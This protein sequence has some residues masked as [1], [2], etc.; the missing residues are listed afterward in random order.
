M[1]VSP[2]GNRPGSYEVHSRSGKTYVV[3]YC[4]SGDTDRE[5]PS[6]WECTCSA[7]NVGSP[8]ICRHVKAVIAWIEEPHS[9]Q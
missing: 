8:K 2:V 7:P 3:R 1:R 6:A 4:G 5:H 9:T